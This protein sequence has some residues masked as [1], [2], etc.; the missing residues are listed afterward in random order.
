MRTYHCEL[1]AKKDPLET[2]HLGKIGSDEVGKPHAQDCLEQ[3]PNVAPDR[4]CVY[5]K[6][7]GRLGGCAWILSGAWSGGLVGWSYRDKNKNKGVSVGKLTKEGKNCVILERGR[8][9][10]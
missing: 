7:E 10:R 2:N 9:I 1:R 6:S 5:P 3:E 4:G 8:V